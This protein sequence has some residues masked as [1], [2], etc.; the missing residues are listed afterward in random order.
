MKLVTKGHASTIGMSLR[1]LRASVQIPSRPEGPS[2]KRQP[3]SPEGLARNPHHDPPARLPW[4][5]HRRGTSLPVLT[6]P[7]KPLWYPSLLGGE[8]FSPTYLDTND[9]LSPDVCSPSIKRRA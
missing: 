1:Y 3:S 6:H 5:R 7:L 9:G 8:G 4:E 2:A